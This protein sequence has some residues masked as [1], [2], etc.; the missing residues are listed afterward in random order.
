MDTLVAEASLGTWRIIEAVSGTGAPF[1]LQIG[2]S[3][4]DGAGQEARMT[5]ARGTRFSIFAATLKLR[6]ANLSGRDNRVIV[7]A[8]EG[9]CVS[10]NHYEVRGVGGSNEAV[11]I[12]IPPFARSVRLDTSPASG[13]MSSTLYVNDGLGTTRAE[14]L[15]DEQP[16]GGLPLAG[17]GALLV[18][19]PAGTSYRVTFTL[20][21]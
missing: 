9:Y 18:S 2:W 20:S 21:L 13:L 1:E 10:E 11:P 5:V 4:G 19:V 7:M 14:V 17:A 6:A 12:E 3:S 16:A 15:G 8:S